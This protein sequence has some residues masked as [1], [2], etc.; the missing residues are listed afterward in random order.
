MVSAGRPVLSA[1]SRIVIGV[2]SL[3]KKTRK[4]ASTREVCGEM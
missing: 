3:A 1:R 2:L 4:T